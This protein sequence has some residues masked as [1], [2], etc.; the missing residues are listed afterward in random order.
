[1]KI[2]FRM[3][4][5]LFVIFLIPKQTFAAGGFSVSPSN[6]NL[7]P[8]G[9]TTITI[10]TNNA[11]GLLNIESTSPDVATVSMG[12]T[13]I[14]QPGQSATFT[15]TANSAGYATINVIATDNFATMDEEILGGQVRT[16]TVNVTN[17]QPAPPQP[18][19]QQK[20]SQPSTPN[21]EPAKSSNTNIRKITVS[22]KEPTRIDDNNFSITVSNS[23]TIVTIDVEKEDAKTTIE[24]LG[25]HELKLGDNEIE[26]KLIAES[27]AERKIKLL[28]TRR[29]GYVISDL[30]EIIK[31]KPDDIV[32]IIINEGEVLD[33]DTL[34]K[35]KQSG[36]LV[37]FNYF[38]VEEELRYSWQIDGYKIKNKKRFN[39]KV[40]IVK[41]YLETID[42]A[43]NYAKG[44]NI[45]LS[46]K[47]DNPKGI[48]LKVFI[49]SQ[50]KTG[51]Q[52]NIYT[53]KN[54]KL[55]LKA[56]KVKVDAGYVTFDISSDT[57]YFI[58]QS[59]L[60]KK[61]SDNSSY[62]FT[63]VVL[64]IIIIV[65]L[66]IVIIMAKRLNNLKHKKSTEAETIVAPDR[67]IIA[68]DNE[69]KQII[70]EIEENPTIET[71]EESPIIEP[72]EENPTIEPEEE[73]S[74]IEPKQ[75]SNKS[76]KSDLL[77]EYLTREK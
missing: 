52:V 64:T 68:S 50:Y 57:D 26:L 30:G 45:K 37:N 59:D 44:I 28:V 34:S 22:G 46:N 49:G 73:K 67:K 72:K 23:V 76:H 58:T 14:Q 62:L 27:G 1:M 41:D 51:Q 8:G 40:D 39:T 2:K 5:L 63:S 42:K 18:Q 29:K 4:L 54:D 74:I 53:F 9:S 3:I 13:F 20:P 10:N 38:N 19:P 47:I 70:G 43:S 33:E 16:I 71:K 31:D 69:D 61:T 17:P 25:D 6:V 21:Q 56:E 75:V 11:V 77:D 15:I 35:V 65:M 24:G 55:Y 48:K 66:I 7:N 12:S 60:N 36:I 32:D